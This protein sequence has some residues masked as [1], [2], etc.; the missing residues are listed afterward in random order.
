M[1]S[2]LPPLTASFRLCANANKPF[3]GGPEP[4]FLSSSSPVDDLARAQPP[5]DNWQADIVARFDL[6]IDGAKEDE[7][8]RSG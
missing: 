2:L 1:S 3:L 7:C 6:F 5:D 4:A 8:R